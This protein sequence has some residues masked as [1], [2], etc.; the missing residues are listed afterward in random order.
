MYGTSRPKT[1][2]GLSLRALRLRWAVAPVGCVA[3]LILAILV[4]FCLLFGARQGPTVATFNIENFP[5]DRRQIVGAFNTIA[6]LDA[7]VVAVQ[8][9]RDPE[10]FRR[11]A[12][13]RLGESWRFV[14]NARG[15]EQRVGVLFDTNRFAFSYARDHAQTQIDGRGKPVLE[16]RLRPLEGGR[17]LRVF[18]LHLK[19]GGDFA[20]VRREQLRQLEPV[21]AEATESWDDIVVLG[22]FNATGDQDREVIDRL[23]NRLGLHWATRGLRCTSYWA[24]R[25]GCL[26]SALD[27]V[28][29]RRLPE[30]AAARGPC[31]TIGCS[32]G[33]RCPAFHREVSDHCPV[34]VRF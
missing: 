6:S 14:T 22:D 20:H 31:E 28:L 24:R 30:E 16:V 4:L 13:A 8:E 25:D 17:A 32:P 3:L 12:R 27:H 33:D 5:R 1:L 18:V 29:T 2:I 19:A 11:S 15:P 7:S 10:V 26:G 34:T 21:L 23:S 9:I